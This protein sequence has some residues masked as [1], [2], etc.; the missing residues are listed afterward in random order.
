MWYYLL[1]TFKK[2]LFFF[3]FQKS[4]GVLLGKSWWRD[5]WQ[6]Q[7]FWF[8][9]GGN[10]WESQF[11]ERRRLSLHCETWK[12]STSRKRVHST[13]VR[14]LTLPVR[15]FLSAPALRLSLS[16]SLSLRI[17]ICIFIA[18]NVCKCFNK[19]LISKCNKV[20]FF[21]LRKNFIE[22]YK[23]FFVRKSYLSYSVNIR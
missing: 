20:F 11:P 21:R 10:N 8:K 2:L 4:N 22:K 19:T 3:K 9:S 17:N 14:Y 18:K 6:C 23:E 16:L 15:I 5:G 12:V 1:A 13:S 7:V